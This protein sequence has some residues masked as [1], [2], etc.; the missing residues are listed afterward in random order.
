M[1]GGQDA[2]RKLSPVLVPGSP[3]VIPGNGCTSRGRIRLVRRGSHTHTVAIGVHDANDYHIGDRH[4]RNIA[5]SYGVGI[6][7]A[8]S[9]SM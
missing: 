9:D 6:A 3:V 7:N 5:T 2:Q 1:S 8:V 4:R